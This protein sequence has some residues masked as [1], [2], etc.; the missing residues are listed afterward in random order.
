[1]IHTDRSWRALLVLA[2][3]LAGLGPSGADAQVS[4]IEI[5][6]FSSTTLT[7]QE[8]LTG[9]KD[10]KPVIIA[11]ELRI[12]RAGTDRLPVVVLLHGSGGV[13]GNID[14]WAQ[15]FNSMGIAAF[16]VDSFTARGIQSTVNDQDQL[17]RLAMTVDAYRALEML[18]KHPRVDPDRI[19]LM[20]FSRGG[21][22][23]LYASLK[24]FQKMHGP[25]GAGFAAYIPFYPSCA[26]AYLDD[27]DVADRP[28]RIFHGAADDYW[29]VG[30]CRT[31]VGRLRTA[32]KDVQLTEYPEAHHVFDWSALKSPVRLAQAQTARHC[33]TEETAN[34]VVVNSETKQPF[35]NKDPCVERGATIA[36]N[37]QAHAEAQKAVRD[38]ARTVLRV[39]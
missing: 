11:G 1:V 30:P 3:L 23:T 27:E 15:M 22:A 5:H 16:I 4:R 26:T 29:P 10:G 36:Y 34:G 17:G 9:K 37:S 2:C 6:P 25:T 7:D 12:P 31:Y 35:T 33:R 32:G 13:G 21:Q 39:K 19:A 24:R 18:A 38:V 20:G 28:I 8:F 14:D